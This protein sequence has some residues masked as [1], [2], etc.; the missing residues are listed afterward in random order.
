MNHKCVFYKKYL[1]IMTTE[2]LRKIG[3]KHLI[4]YPVQKHMVFFYLIIIIIIV[5]GRTPN[6]IKHPVECFRAR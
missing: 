2:T 1:T 6:V 4:M 3:Q 5:G